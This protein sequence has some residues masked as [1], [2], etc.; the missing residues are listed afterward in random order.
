VI[1]NA[2][3]AEM[4][5]RTQSGQE[6]G[7]SQE[8]EFLVPDQR[9]MQV[10]SAPIRQDDKVSGVVLVFHD[11]TELRRLENIRKEFVANVSH[12]LRTPVASIKGYAETL[13]DGALHDQD[14]AEDFVRIIL[15]DAQRLAKLIE[16]LLDLSSIESGKL[17]RELTPCSLRSVLDRVLE[18]VYM[19][20]S[21]RN[22]AI[23]VTGLDHDVV[24]KGDDL[25]LFRLFLNLIENAVK[26][27]NDGG[28]VRVEVAPSEM[29]VEIK[30][31]DSGIGIPPEDISRIFERFYRVDK[32]HSRQMGGTGL[33]LSIVK[34]IVQSHGGT[35]FVESVLNQGSVFTVSL[36]RV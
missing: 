1:R 14:N 20:S 2:D 17:M 28:F 32:A 5:A 23:T 36:P 19:Q 30:V 13:I 16:D 9:M 3:I 35:V 7:Y 29:M 26:Y 22:I 8:L 12:E 21:A 6:N 27:N 25:G 15:S 11:I 34:H 31:I 24:V 4:I 18:G 10:Q 33:G